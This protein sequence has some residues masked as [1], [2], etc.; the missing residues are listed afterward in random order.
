MGA[1]MTALAH[2]QRLLA[3]RRAFPPGSPDRAYRERAAWV[4]LQMARGVAVLDYT[5][6][7]EPKPQHRMA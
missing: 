5:P 6:R 3:E 7:P 4:L 1:L 2:A